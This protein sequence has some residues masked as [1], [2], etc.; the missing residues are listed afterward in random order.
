MRKPVLST[1]LLVLLLL[2]LV[3]AALADDDAG[4]QTVALVSGNGS[5]PGRDP[6]DE[7]STDG[8]VTWDQ[9]YIVTNYPAWETPI[10]GSEWIS[11]DAN[12]GLPVGDNQE[13]RY[14]RFFDLPKDC[15]ATSLSVVL[16]IDNDAHL[17]LNGVEFGST[18]L[19]QLLSN[20]QGAPEGPF[21]ATGPFKQ[22][23]NLL[24]FRGDGSRVVAGLDYEATLTCAGG[25]D[26]DDSGDD[27]GDHGDD[28][29]E[30]D[31]HHDDGDHEHHD[32]GHDD[33]EDD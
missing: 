28:D 14:R 3:P 8:G 33:H 26:E 24:E 25:D 30:H 6:L 11:I 27:D 5:P 29:G 2:S 10:P 19:G 18:P 13:I 4:P 31:H 16:H 21:L 20:F 23:A 9:G 32:P 1:V 15:H 17:F 7:F 22:A 12:R